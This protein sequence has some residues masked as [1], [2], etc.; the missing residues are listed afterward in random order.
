MGAG[1]LAKPL[2]GK[3]LL[4][5]AA[6][7]FANE[8][9]KP[10]GAQKATQAAQA[11]A[12]EAQAEEIRRQTAARRELEKLIKSLEPLSGEEKN[13]LIRLFPGKET[14]FS[15][16]RGTGDVDLLMQLAGLGSSSGAL[17]SASALAQ[18]DIESGRQETGDTVNALV[19]LLLGMN[20]PSSIEQAIFN[21]PTSL[22]GMG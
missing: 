9:N 4:P 13:A 12:A 5:A 16:V 1:L 6:G 8:L 22:I 20:R 15:G 11:S 2:V 19:Q 17:N 10:S 7:L 18:R 14:D 21:N 3:F